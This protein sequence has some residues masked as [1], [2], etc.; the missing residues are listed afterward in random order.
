M[1]LRLSEEEYAELMRRRGKTSS[2]SAGALPPS[3]NAP[4][5]LPKGQAAAAR[6]WNPKDSPRLVA[7]AEGSGATAIKGKA[8]K[9]GNQRV[10]IDGKKFDSKHEAEVYGELMLRRRD[11]ELQVVIRQVS[12]DLPGGIRYIADFVTVDSEGRFE[13]LDA[14]SEATRKNRVYINK[15]KQMLSEWGIVIKEV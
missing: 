7:P 1:T 3:L 15:K 10:E 6:G 14:K 2:V 9:Y 13:V 5:L 4:P 12:F 11:G 8:N